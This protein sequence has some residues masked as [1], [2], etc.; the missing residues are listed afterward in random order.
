MALFT[1]CSGTNFLIGVIS[2]R[3]STKACSNF[4]IDDS[5]IR[6]ELNLVLT[7]PR[8]DRKI[9][10]LKSVAVYQTMSGDMH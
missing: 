5:K 10:W 2:S 3:L 7:L 8:K 4:Y 6:C 1:L 9:E